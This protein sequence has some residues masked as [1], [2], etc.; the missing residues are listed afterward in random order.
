M[1]MSGKVQKCADATTNGVGFIIGR[2]SG[3]LGGYFGFPRSQ[4]ESLS[5]RVLFLCAL[6]HS[7]PAPPKLSNQIGATLHFVQN[8]L[9][10]IE[11]LND[12]WKHAAAERCQ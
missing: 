8:P 9:V 1:Q 11:N 7:R 5:W 12:S 2:R 10:A 4:R 6:S 3:E